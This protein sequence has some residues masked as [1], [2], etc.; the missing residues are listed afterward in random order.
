MQRED[1]G[2]LNAFANVAHEG[3]F[4]K[5]AARLGVSQS[6]LSHTVRRLEERLGVRL[7]S[8]TTRSV[9][10][11]L[12]GERL[13]K[14]LDPALAAI[15]N[16]LRSLGDLRDVPAGKIRITSSRHAAQTVL[17]PKL[18]DFLR[19]YE[20]I[21]IELSVDSGLADIVEGRFDAG[22]RLGEAVDK[23]MIAVRIGP[24]VRMVVVGSPAYIESAGTPRS[25]EALSSHECIAMRFQTA[26]TI[27]AWELSNGKRDVNVRPYGRL[28]F[29][30]TT[31]IVNAAIDGFGFGFVMED[32]VV[33]HVESGRLVRVLEDWCPSFA[34]HH[35]YYPS[36]R[37]PSA[38]FGLLVEALRQRD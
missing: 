11:T 29:D 13:L 9:A 15:G 32:E 17:W 2:D 18:R 28:I 6:A 31:E 24:D 4:T 10:P 16:E 20:E 23:D 12:A 21:E 1:L 26:K 30:S 25:P 38:A 37:Q 36:R 35:L 5:A 14:T 22:V 27:Y 34:G 8:R 3:S 33:D 19:E 7:L